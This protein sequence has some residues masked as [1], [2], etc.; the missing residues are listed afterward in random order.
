MENLSHKDQYAYKKGYNST[1]TLIKAQHAWLELG[2]AGWRRQDGQ[3]LS[4]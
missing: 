2:M 4:V 1:M 3:S